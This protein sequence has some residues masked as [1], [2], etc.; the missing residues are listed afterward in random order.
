[1][2]RCIHGGGKIFEMKYFGTPNTLDGCDD[3]E[4]IIKSSNNCEVLH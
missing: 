3:C 4:K 1:M 2:T